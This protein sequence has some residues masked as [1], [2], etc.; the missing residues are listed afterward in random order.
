MFVG[1]LY[2]V[3]IIS[4]S[5]AIVFVY[6]HV[7]EGLLIVYWDI[8]GWNTALTQTSERQKD[9]KKETLTKV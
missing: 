4:S 1:Y 7:N 2:H 3:Y 6:M 5:L 9:S 8:E